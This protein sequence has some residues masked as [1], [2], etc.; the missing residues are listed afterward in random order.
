MLKRFWSS[1][2]SAALE[3]TPWNREAMG[4]ILARCLAFFLLRRCSITEYCLKMNALPL[5]NQQVCGEV[6]NFICELVPYTE[7]EMKMQATPYRSFREFTRKYYKHSCNTTY[8]HVYHQKM[9]PECKNITRQNCVTKWETDANGQQVCN[10]LTYGHHELQHCCLQICYLNWEDVVYFL[11]KDLI[12]G[13]LRLV[14]RI[15]CLAF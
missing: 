9:I 15:G 3:R 6:V 11:R 14:Y 4:S 12:A 7:C 2:W 13:S 1:D 8:E 5:I 10:F